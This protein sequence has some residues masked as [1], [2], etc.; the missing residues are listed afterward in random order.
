MELIGR[1]KTINRLLET[2][3]KMPEDEKA[4]YQMIALFL[5]NKEE[6]PTE[7]VVNDGENDGKTD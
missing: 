1:E 5:N 2:A 4:R 6:F 3:E 7:L